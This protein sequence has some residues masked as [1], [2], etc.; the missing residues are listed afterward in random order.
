V[1]VKNVGGAP[2]REVVQLYVSAPGKSM[3]KPA[4]ELRRFAK[5]RMLPPGEQETLSF[6]LTA[7]DLASFDEASSSWQV[8]AGSYT[9]KVGASSEDIRQTATFAKAAAGTVESALRPFAFLDTSLPIDRRVDDLVSR[10]TL[11]EKASQLVNRTRAVPRLGVPEYNLWSEALHGVANN[12][13]VTVFPQAIGL[14]ATFDAPLLKRM[15]KATAREA[16]VKWNLATRSG[17]AGQIFRGLT[18]F[19][20][21]I[22]IFR[23]PR[24]GRGQETYGED[25]YLTGKLGVA[26][27]TGLQGDP[28]HPT[29]T[30]TAKHYAVH[31]GPEPL[32]HG[33]D[34]K[35]SAH[36]LEDT[37]LPAFRAAVVDGKVKSVMCVYNAVNGVPGC[38]SELL[39]DGTLREQWG[40]QGFVT[41]DCDAVRDI[42]TGHKYVSSAAEAGAV[43][44]TAGLDNDCTT[45]S[46]GFGPRGTPD[47]QRYLDALK[48]GLLSEAE[49]DVALKRMLRT[50]FQLGLFDPPETVKAGRVEDSVLDSPAHRQLALQLARESMVLLKNDGVLPLQKAPVRIAV[51]GPLADS[52]RV[53]LGNYNGY[54]SRSTTALDG[55]RQQFPEATVVFEPGTKF[56]RP[57]PLVPTSALSTDT[58]AAGLLA[59]V[60][61]DPD[62]SGTPLETRTDPEVAL[63][64]DFAAFFSSDAPRAPGRPT[65]WS[66]WLTPEESGTYRLG[67]EGMGNRLFLDGKKLVDTTGGFPPPP[68]TTEV[69][70]EKGHRYAIKVEAVPRFFASTRLVW[71]PPL[72]DIETRA[73]AAAG[74]ADVVVAVVGITSDLEG[75]ESGVDQPGFKGGDRTSLDLPAEEQQLLE[76]VGATG[77]PLVVVVMSGSAIALNWAKEHAN[78]I[79]QAWYPGEEGGTAIAETL[80]GVSNPAGRLP[81]TLYT[82][83]EQLPDFTDYSMANRTYR[84]FT[85]TPL[86]PFG[87]GLSYSTFAYSGLHLAKPEIAAGEPLDVA[88]DVRNTSDRDGDEV[89]QAYL[90][91]P[92]LPGAPSHALRAFTRVHLKAGESRTVR[93][94][95]TERD[96]SHVDEAGA[97]V[98]APGQYRISVGGG[99]PGTVAPTAEAPFSIT[100]SKALPR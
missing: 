22:N 69:T 93:L 74:E 76:A 72:S 96:L 87:Y 81:V 58:G 52:S 60:Y 16:R 61:A 2:G 44:I 28:D 95:L 36:D 48:E 4:L 56:L 51:V 91:F 90:V 49:V 14:G 67:V 53:L 12:G 79:L 54:P 77:K 11:E 89:V 23:D 29:A 80:A 85:G 13:G 41:G 15:A 3:P 83:V 25:P 88:V 64:A 92:K 24:W 43:A 55:L 94:A 18:F 42:E 84:Y 62:M 8:E 59:E 33:F 38:A 37:Y 46:L 68:D 66:G 65:R 57:N 7:R 26:F 9:V 35:A 86:Y 45:S 5:T 40:F 50:R 78:A 73:V 19:S 6:T 21:N 97:R 30:A 99:Q 70:L 98:V 47:Y 27:I 34:A 17:R 39:L 10:M 32:R 100:G 20:P 1:T 82:G 31:S 75:E 71:M 63:G